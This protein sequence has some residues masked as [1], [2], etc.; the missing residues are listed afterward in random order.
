MVE[1]NTQEEEALESPYTHLKPAILESE[2]RGLL[3]W[4]VLNEALIGDT[5][6]NKEM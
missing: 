2:R 5:N 6:L 4:N 3:L 1:E